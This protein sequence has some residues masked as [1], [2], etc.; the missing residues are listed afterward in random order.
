MFKSSNCK[1]ALAAYKIK[2][3]HLQN[4]SSSL[5]N[6]KIPSFTRKT[7]HLPKHFFKWTKLSLIFESI[8]FCGFLIFKTEHSQKL[9]LFSKTNATRYS[10]IFFSGHCSVFV[11]RKYRL[12][13]K[14]SIN[15]SSYQS[16]IQKEA[17]ICKEVL[18]S[19]KCYG[20]NT[21]QL[22]LLILFSRWLSNLFSFGVFL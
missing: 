15:S 14:I 6:P 18:I 16:W 21:V 3:C 4:L 11:K 12:C 17:N 22:P 13:E 8:N 2:F 5:V 20:F 1:T 9:I 19:K 7:G 10:S